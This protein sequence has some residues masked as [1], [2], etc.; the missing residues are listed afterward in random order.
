MLKIEERKE[1]KYNDE[2]QEEYK[3]DNPVWH[4]LNEIHKDYSVNTEMKFYSPEYCRF[5]SSIEINDLISGMVAYS[6]LINDFYVVGRTP[7]RSSLWILNKSVVCN[8]MVLKEDVSIE[9]KEN[10]VELESESQKSNLFDLVNLVQPGYFVESTSELGKYFGIYKNDRLIAV[11]GERMKMNDYTEISAVVTHPDYTRN[12]YA[13]QLIR[14][15]INKILNDGKTPYLHVSEMNIGAIR[16][17][18]KL[19]FRFRSKITFWNLK[20]GV[21]YD[22]EKKIK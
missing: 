20:A 5:G 19:G 11:S 9:I 12:G 2:M 13:K 17:Y 14:H 10:I 22:S 4:S 15:T 16:L 6:N 1:S 8:Q 3:L 18:E 7:I 21:E